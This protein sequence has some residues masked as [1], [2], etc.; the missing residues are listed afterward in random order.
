MF[1]ITGDRGLLHVEFSRGLREA[2]AALESVL[3]A[4]SRA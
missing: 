1:N 2:G 4:G 3:A